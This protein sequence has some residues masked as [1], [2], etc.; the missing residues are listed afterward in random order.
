MAH[1]RRV[2]L[3]AL[4]LALG[5][6][7]G[8]S[9]STGEDEGFDR[10]LAVKDFT[11]QV[12]G[13][14]EDER[15][16]KTEGA[17]LKANRRAQLEGTAELA[18]VDDA[19]PPFAHWQGVLKGSASGT[20][21]ETMVTKEDPPAT[22]TMS[23]TGQGQLEDD[24]SVDLRMDT[25]AGTYEVWITFGATKGRLTMKLGDGDANTTDC[26]AV[27][28]GN[29]G[30]KKKLPATGL[31]I[32]AT[33]KTATLGFPTAFL[34]AIFFEKPSKAKVDWTIRPKGEQEVELLVSPPDDYETWRPEATDSE[35][36]PGNDFV[37]T[38]ELSPKGG[39]TLLSEAS[40]IRFELVECSEEP[41]VCMNS[42]VN[43]AKRNDLRFL[44]DRNS[45]Q[46]VKVDG[47]KAAH[48]TPSKGGCRKATATISCFDWGAWGKLKVTAMVR[49][50]EIVG[51][52]GTDKTKKELLIPKRDPDSKIADAWKKKFPGAGDKAD[53][54]DADAEPEGDGDAGD[55]LTLYEEYRGFVED[56]VRV[57][58]SPLKKD[59]FIRNEM[60]GRG[61]GGIALYAQL[62][63]LE[64]H[65]KLRAN[66]L[67]ARR[68]TLNAVNPNWGAGAHGSRHQHAIVLRE[69]K[70]LGG[71]SQGYRKD[72]MTE[73]GTPRQ[74]EYVQVSKPYPLPRELES[75]I[76]HELLH[77][78]NVGHHGNIAGETS[79]TWIARNGKVVEQVGDAGSRQE[80]QVEIYRESDGRRIIA[81]RKGT[82]IVF[83]TG[84]EDPTLNGVIFH[85]RVGHQQGLYSG[86]TDCVMRYYSAEAYISWA[87]AFYRYLFDGPSGN[88]EV[89]GTILCDKKEDAPNGV[90]AKDH[91][92]RPR[93][94]E[95]DSGCCKKSVCINDSKH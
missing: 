95:A 18:R 14:V 12:N 26:P 52:L 89:P 7:L 16:E 79:S 42:P 54:S 67:D 73:P 37:V 34:Q 20:A 94:G 30:P 38:A 31:I 74:F 64:V 78:S 9:V 84:M 82:R 55:G 36:K 44:Q 91:Q 6:A 83:G 15:D 65:G 45:K 39:G 86:R 24:A 19:S 29:D 27:M 3:P 71:P 93:C 92:P 66:E 85:L 62:T 90:N 68:A 4:A 51:A 49:G 53:D 81:E 77:A 80:I 56:G 8:A 25:E 13:L 57:P 69:G 48:L 58:V 41:G 17:V 72:G 50:K 2:L 61:A 60:G 11:I 63:G 43:G 40:E 1:P 59:L 47:E 10:F 32:S 87:S 70:V 23:W 28:V 76:V 46:G 35:A 21:S 88:G 33:R 22:S 75:N 5:A